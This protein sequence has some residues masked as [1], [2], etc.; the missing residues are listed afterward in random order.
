MDIKKLKE[1]L[2]RHE[3]LSLKPY[4]CTANKLTIGYGRNLEDVGI[5]QEEASFLLA[6]DIKKIVTQVSEKFKWF[7]TLSPARQAVVVNMIY[8]LGLNGFSNFK[9]T[10]R[11]LESGQ[12]EQAAIEMLESKWA[13]Q[14]GKRAKE[15]S[16]IMLEG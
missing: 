4:K 15:L 5:S 10:I 8:N 6:N 14:V 1:M 12:F 16:K 13:S 11:F 2:M 7:K 3:G 9:N